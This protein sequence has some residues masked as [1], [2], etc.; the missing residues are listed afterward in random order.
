[1]FASDT[2]TYAVLVGERD[3]AD[4]H[5]IADLLARDIPGETKIVLPGVGHMPNI[6]GPD[7][8]TKSSS[9]FPFPHGSSCHL[10]HSVPLGI[11]NR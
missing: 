10:T 8:L 5:A 2:R 3:L 9:T 11:P 1:M 6:E 4:F 7:N